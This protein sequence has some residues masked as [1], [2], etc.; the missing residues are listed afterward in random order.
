MI[1][2]WLI[3]VSNY[4]SNSDVSIDW[5]TIPNSIAF[6]M[7]HYLLGSKIATKNDCIESP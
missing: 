1:L 2:G 6:D 3:I 5:L 4:L 7:T